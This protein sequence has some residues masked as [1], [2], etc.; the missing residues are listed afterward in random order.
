[1]IHSTYKG[2]N[3][4]IMRGYGNNTYLWVDCQ[5]LINFAPMGH[6]KTLYQYIDEFLKTI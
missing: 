2:Y 3:I 5:C 6:L 1:M 4:Y